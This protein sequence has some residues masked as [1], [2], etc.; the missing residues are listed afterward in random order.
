MS[1][2][3]SL[4]DIL[5]PHRGITAVIGSGG[6]STLLAQGAAALAER[7][8]RVVLATSTHMLPPEGI[9]LVRTDKE[10]HA[11]LEEHAVA[12]IGELD[13]A[14]GKL[15]SPTGGFDTLSACADYV[16]VEADGSHRLPLKAHASY[17]PVIPESTAHTILVVGAFG[18]NRPIAEVVH[19]PEIFCQL[20]GAA[21]T[22]LATPELVARA[23]ASEALVDEASTVIVNQA[24]G[25]EAR[26][27]AK[28]FAETL[29]ELMPVTVYAG[30]IYSR[31][32]TSISRTADVG[33]GCA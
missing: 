12:A 21:P 19:R 24:E 31:R 7:G 28:E 1:A 17:E 30:S 4:F 6:K 9:P 8:A 15:S 25:T 22:D 23:A 11:A 29:S 33:E 26:V 13:P 3:V 2:I 16:L 27:A 14:T 20:T 18:F 10:L 5:S 32:L